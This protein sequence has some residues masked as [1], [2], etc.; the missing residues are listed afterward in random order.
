MEEDESNVSSSVS[1]LL[2]R[3]VKILKVVEQER[4]ATIDRSGRLKLEDVLLHYNSE[5]WYLKEF[6]DILSDLDALK[7]LYNTIGSSPRYRSVVKK[8]MEAQ[9]G[10]EVVG[11][12]YRHKNLERRTEIDAIPVKRNRR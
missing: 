5:V 6:K 7:G 4:K 10:C 8:H 9:P 3:A 12:D 11:E 2:E 1:K